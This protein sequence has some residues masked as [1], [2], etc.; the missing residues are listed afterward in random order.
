M[1]FKRFREIVR[2]LKRR[3]ATP[4]FC[5]RCGSPEL[6]FSS[7]FEAYPKLYG[8]APTQYLCERCGYKGPIAMEIDENE[9]IGNDEET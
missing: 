6:E 5:P 2:G 8:I 7:S 3:R 9:K 4:K 1:V